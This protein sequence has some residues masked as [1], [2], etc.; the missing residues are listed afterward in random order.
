MNKKIL[1]NGIMVFSISLLI[2]MFTLFPTVPYRDSGE[3]ITSAY[4][5]GNTHPPGSPL[6]MLIGKLFSFIP[7]GAVAWRLNVMSAF[8]SALTVLIVFLIMLRVTGI[9]NTLS[10]AIAAL[11]VAFSRVFWLQAV[12]AELFALNGFFLALMIYIAV[13]INRNYRIYI[14]LFSYVFGLSI[15]NHQ[16]IIL[17]FPAFAYFFWASSKENDFKIKSMDIIS[18]LLFFMLGFSLYLYL[19][20]RAAHNPSLNW[21]DP[22]KLERVFSVI[23]RRDYG[24]LSL[25]KDAMVP[26]TLS[27]MSR[28]LITFI[29][30][31]ARQFTIPVFLVGLA[32]IYALHK[33]KMILSFFL[34]LIFIFSGPIFTVLANVASDNNAKAMIERFYQMPAIIFS[35]WVGL[36]TMALFEKIKADILKK[37]LAVILISFLILFNFHDANKSRNYLEFDYGINILD[38]IPENTIIFTRRDNTRNILWYLQLVEKRRPDVKMIISPMPFWWT[39]YAKEKWPGLKLQLNNNNEADIMAIINDNYID[40]PIYSD[41]IESEPLG[42]YYDYW[43]PEG[44]IFKFVPAK[45]DSLDISGIKKLYNKLNT[46]SYRGIHDKYFRDDTFSMEIINYYSESYFNYGAIYHNRGFYNDA[47]REFQKAIEINP[48]FE[49]AKKLYEMDKTLIKS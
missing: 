9:G 47:V 7:L 35:I 23:L 43:M 30:T 41:N 2:Y 27:S 48:N 37:L 12:Q 8:F 13:R 4:L 21:N 39:E 42:K 49:D 6:Y 11:S 5:L 22:D 46:Y 14:W 40:Y 1:I 3:L 19:P 17:A 38:S 25:N 26:H 29:V 31:M 10:S 20:V 36:G 24:T 33:K 28:Q 45:R 16:M 15:C 44:V 32:G 34:L 18:A